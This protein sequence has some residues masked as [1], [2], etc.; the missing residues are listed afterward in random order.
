MIN[1]FLV[2]F[3]GDLQQPKVITSRSL[4][5]CSTKKTGEKQSWNEL[6]RPWEIRKS[7]IPSSKQST[8]SYILTYSG[9]QT[10]RTWYSSI[11]SAEEILISA[12]TVHSTEIALTKTPLFD[13]WCC[14]W[15]SALVPLYHDIISQTCT[16]SMYCNDNNY[17]NFYKGELKLYTKC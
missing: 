9:L 13:F 5:H 2:M 15:V 11:F 3:L 8:K 10:E 14:L 16:I 7:R 6:Q 17:L 4:L 1:C 12:S